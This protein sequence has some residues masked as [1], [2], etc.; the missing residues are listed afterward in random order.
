MLD[1][2]GSWVN[3]LIAGGICVVAPEHLAP[4][5]S[6]SI[7][8]AASSRTEEELVASESEKKKG[9][10]EE[11]F[12]DTRS[13]ARRIETA[14]I[15]KFSWIRLSLMRGYLQFCPRPSRP[16]AAHGSWSGELC[17]IWWL[18]PGRAQDLPKTRSFTIYKVCKPSAWCPRFVWGSGPEA[19]P[20]PGNIWLRL[21]EF[22]TNSFCSISRKIPLERL[23]T[24]I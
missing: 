11:S 23:S 18:R 3:G 24:P 21:L 2:L 22:R 8:D 20:F 16:R 12:E 13:Q 19:A 14:S 17:R 6:L 9:K 5:L 10:E 15:G 7:G 1:S 4:I